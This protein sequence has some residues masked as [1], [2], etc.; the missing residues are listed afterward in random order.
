MKSAH[1]RKTRPC[2]VLSTAT[3]PG[4][5]GKP[6]APRHSLAELYP[7]NPVWQLPIVT[8]GG[9][10]VTEC[11]FMGQVVSNCDTWEGPKMKSET[12]SSQ[13]ECLRPWGAT[14]RWKNSASWNRINIRSI[15]IDLKNHITGYNALCKLWDGSKVS[16]QKETLAESPKHQEIM[17]KLG[18]GEIN[19][20]Y[21][22][23]LC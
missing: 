3:L 10:C 8:Y 19:K 13:I 6:G 18:Y 21:F 15:N 5:S 17:K 16:F 22:R 9:G 1:G 2:T 12:G 14:M 20:W 11:N 23:I 4:F 7:Q